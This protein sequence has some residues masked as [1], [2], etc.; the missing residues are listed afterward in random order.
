MID[1]SPI[2]SDHVFQKFLIH[3]VRRMALA[4]FILFAVSLITFIAS[5]VAGDPLS[6]RMSPD[7]AREY[8]DLLAE[9]LALDKPRIQQYFIFIGNAWTL[10][11]GD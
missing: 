7:A 3:L 6:L 11:F 5:R 8:P 4:I 10:D 9:E 2:A 1:S